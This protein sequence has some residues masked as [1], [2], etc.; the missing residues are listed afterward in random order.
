[1]KLGIMACIIATLSGC[2]TLVEKA[3][4]VLDGSLFAEQTQG[5]YRALEGMELRQVQAKDGSES[6][7]VSLSAYPGLR[8]RASAPER[9][10]RVFLQTLYF[11][12]SSYEGWNELTL[13]LTGEARLIIS[14]TSALWRGGESLDRV[15]ITGGKIR[16]ELNRL[17]GE[18]A[19]KALRNR[20]ERIAALT[21][22]MHT[23]PDVPD[24]TGEEDFTAYWKPM[25]LP[26]LVPRKKRPPQWIEDHA[27]W[28][29]AEDLRWNTSYT[30]ALFPEALGT[31]RNSGALLRDWEEALGW[32]YVHYQWDRILDTLSKE[33]TLTK[34]R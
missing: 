2:T 33:Y 4:Q 24:F 9:D 18:E 12:G 23:Q 29:Q 15:R 5:V 17:S 14:R 20:D 19:L 28:V 26:E 11:L 13:E 16:R 34:I 7:L 3:G 21:E 30:A 8:F 32:I 31:L 22:W 6:I 27:F 25:L 10:G 1:M